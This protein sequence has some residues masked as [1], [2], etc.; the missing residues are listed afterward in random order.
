[1]KDFI[2]KVHNKCIRTIKLYTGLPHEPRKIVQ[3]CKVFNIESC[4]LVRFLAI[5]GRF[6]LQIHCIL[7]DVPSSPVLLSLG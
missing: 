6:V 4:I 7:A 5:I 2:R 3:I 1:M